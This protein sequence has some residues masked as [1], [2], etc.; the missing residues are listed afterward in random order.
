MTLLCVF[1]GHKS[2]SAETWNCGYFF[3]RCGRCGADM[4]RSNEAFRPVP[5]GHRVVW[6]AG[7]YHEHSVAPDHR[8]TLP[9][10]HEA[11]DRPAAQPT[12]GAWHRELLHLASAANGESGPPRLP[13]PAEAEHEERP[14]PWIFAAALIA[15]AGLQTLLRLPDSR[16][17]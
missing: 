6:K 3:S 7:H 2:S 15:G 10:L 11:A 1:L 14:Y 5:R 13:K 17:F 4:I 12:L 9:I 16:G 8:R